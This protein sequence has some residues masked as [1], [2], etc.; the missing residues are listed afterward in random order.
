MRLREK[1]HV[2]S[3]SGLLSLQSAKAGLRR[4]IEDYAVVYVGSPLFKIVRLIIVAIFSIHLFACIFYRVKEVSA[5][6]KDDVAAFY[7]SKNVDSEVRCS[8][9]GFCLF[10]ALTLTFRLGVAEH[11]LQ[12]REPPFAKPVADLP[13]P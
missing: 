10:L 13:S 7:T 12:I 1:S 6:S 9:W 8:G 4:A 2:S 5:Q 11:L 3:S